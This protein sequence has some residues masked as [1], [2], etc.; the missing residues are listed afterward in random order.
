[1]NKDFLS[2][3]LLTVLWLLSQGHYA[4]VRKSPLT[5][6]LMELLRGVDEE[7][8]QTYFLAQ[9]TQHVRT[10]VFL[11][12]FSLSHTYTLTLTLTLTLILT[13]TLTLTLEL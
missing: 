4:R 1:M 8:D 3:I 9:I 2:L 11:F 12:S 5:S 13:L 6:G 10:I 7:K